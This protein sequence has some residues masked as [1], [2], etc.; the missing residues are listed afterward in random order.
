[1]NSKRHLMMLQHSEKDL[2]ACSLDSKIGQTKSAKK[3][4]PATNVAGASR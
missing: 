1:M 3:Q 2:F 4:T